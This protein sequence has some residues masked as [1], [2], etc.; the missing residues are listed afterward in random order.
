MMQL[1]NLEKKCAR[2]AGE[3]GEKDLCEESLEGRQ[4]QAQ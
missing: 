2:S 1:H 4:A 3:P